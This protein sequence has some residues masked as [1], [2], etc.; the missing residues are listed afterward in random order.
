MHPLVQHQNP[1]LEP[2]V[3]PGELVG[4]LQAADTNHHQSQEGQYPASGSGPWEPKDVPQAARQGGKDHDQGD[5][6][7]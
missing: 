3:F 5:V 6:D 1:F 7:L 2:L 4:K